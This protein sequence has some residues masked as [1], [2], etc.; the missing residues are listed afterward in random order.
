MGF[1]EVLR[2]PPVGQMVCVHVVLEVYSHSPG[3]SNL[4]E[5]GEDVIR[6]TTD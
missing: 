5:G 6:G 4:A 1:W 3:G 2:C